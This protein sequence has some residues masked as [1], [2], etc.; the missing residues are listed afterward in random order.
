MRPLIRHK[1]LQDLAAN[2]VS[3]VC[4]DT[5]I[6]PKITPLSGEELQGRTS[7]NSNEPINGSREKECQKFY[8]R[9]AQMISEK[10][11][12]PQSLSSLLWVAK[13]ESAL[14]KG[15]ENSM[16]KNCGIRN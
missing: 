4:K 2:M 3:E 13:I 9:L 15:V 1:D 11:D 5:K 16:Q 6:E 12:L 14:F 10:K 8:S 7:N